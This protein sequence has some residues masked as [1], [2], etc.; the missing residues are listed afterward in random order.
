MSKVIKYCLEAESRG[1]VT[2]RRQSWHVYAKSRGQRPAS[3][4][5]GVATVEL[6]V[7]LFVTP[8]LA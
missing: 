8:L 3:S 6:G 5:L 4:S 2:Y 7:I 1:T